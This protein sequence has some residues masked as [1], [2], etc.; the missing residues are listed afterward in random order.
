[1]LIQLLPQFRNLDMQT[2]LNLTAQFENEL[3]VSIPNSYKSFLIE[4]VHQDKIVDTLLSVFSQNQR[5]VDSQYLEDEYTITINQT[6]KIGLSVLNT[7]LDNG[8][9]KCASISL[10]SNIF[11]FESILKDN[12]INSIVKGFALLPF[13]INYDSLYWCIGIGK[14]NYGQIFYCDLWNKTFY[15]S[16]DNFND[17]FSKIFIGVEIE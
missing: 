4:Y 12:H 1:M 14:L 7:Y 11:S 9:E 10:F 5:L 8:I 13:A 2:H 16:N 17:Y 6:H 3:G 15:K